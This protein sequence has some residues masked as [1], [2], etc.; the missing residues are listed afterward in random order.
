MRVREV[1]TSDPKCCTPQTKLDEVARIMA[2]QDCGAVP[3]VDDE[4]S[5]HLIGMI[6]D[7]DITV[8]TLAQGRNPLEMAVR[9]CM[10]AH[11]LAT[12]RAEDELDEAVRRMEERQVRRIPV[13]DEQ[14]ACRGIVAQADI[15]REAPDRVTAEIVQEVSQ[16]NAGAP[17][18][19]P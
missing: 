13:V 7:R 6:T 15:A 17:S 12:V 10:T 18:N 4:R 19:R 3:V 1:M 14:G 5:R 2:A 16:P 8:R 9:D 11:D